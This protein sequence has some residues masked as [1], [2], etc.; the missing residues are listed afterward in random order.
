MLTVS[1]FYFKMQ[2]RN[3]MNTLFYKTRNFICWQ[4]EKER[5]GGFFFKKNIWFIC[6][7]HLL[8]PPKWEIDL[9]K[10]EAI[11]EVGVLLD[12]NN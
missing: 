4:M 1:L 10:L 7:P 9:I 8:F 6:K 12:E 11:W 5:V 2:Y 3:V